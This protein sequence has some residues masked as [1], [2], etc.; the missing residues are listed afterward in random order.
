[1]N[2]AE[3]GS[4]PF[5]SARWSEV[6]SPIIDEVHQHGERRLAFA[7]H[8]MDR[9]LAAQILRQPIHALTDPRILKPMPQQ[10]SRVAL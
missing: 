2:C 4:T 5:S 6:K 1:M 9:N 7:A 3:L 8:G 10:H